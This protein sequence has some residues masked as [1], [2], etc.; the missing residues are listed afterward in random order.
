MVVFS[1]VEVR[2]V[3]RDLGKKRLDGG[4]AETQV[5]CQFLEGMALPRPPQRQEERSGAIVP[6]PFLV[7]PLAQE[8]AELCL[9]DPGPEVARGVEKG[10]R[11]AQEEIRRPVHLR[12]VG[13]EIAVHVPGPPPGPFRVEEQ[14]VLQLR[15]IAAQKPQLV[16]GGEAQGLAGLPDPG[17]ALEPTPLP[18][19]ATWRNAQASVTDGSPSRRY[20]TGRPGSV[21]AKCR[22]WPSSWRYAA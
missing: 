9:E 22:A 16:K 17:K 4:A 11:V 18:E 12:G 6:V 21:L 13:E 10:I 1:F 7:E 3:G 5:G 20:S 14:L 15:G 2:E 19:Q 8:I